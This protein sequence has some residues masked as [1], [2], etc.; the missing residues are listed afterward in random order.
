MQQPR[1]RKSQLQGRKSQTQDQIPRRDSRSQVFSNSLSKPKAQPKRK[2]DN[3]K[4]WKM[5][6]NSEGAVREKGKADPEG[7]RQAGRK[8]ETH[9][10]CHRKA[11]H[12]DS[13]RAEICSRT[14]SGLRSPGSPE[15]R[16]FP[17]K[18]KIAGQRSGQNALTGQNDHTGNPDPSGMLSRAQRHR[19][20]QGTGQD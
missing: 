15:N 10:T 7:K 2:M 14:H 19:R 12:R 5:T 9:R 17:G 18:R 1:C 3:E 8:P 16:L 4:K 20:S 6:N 11:H 13:S